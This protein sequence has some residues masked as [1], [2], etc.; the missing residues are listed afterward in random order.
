M[1]RD[2]ALPAQAPVGGAQPRAS[3]EGAAIG[4]AHAPPSAVEARRHIAS[5]EGALR[6]AQF[7]MRVTLFVLAVIALALAAPTLSRGTPWIDQPPVVLTIGLGGILGCLLVLTAIL[8]RYI[9]KPARRL[10]VA[11]DELG[12]LYQEARE[13]SLQDILTGL[14]NHRAFQEELDRRLSEVGR[15]DTELSLLLLDID[16]FKAVNDAHGHAVGDRVLSEMGATIRGLLRRPDLAFRIGGDEFALL[17]PHTNAEAARVVGRRLLAT[18]LQPRRDPLPSISFSAGISSAPAMARDRDE[19]Y[20]QAD[21]ALYRAK[22]Q[23]R[24][25]VEVF[26]RNRDRGASGVATNDLTAAVSRAASPA[27][28]RAV[29]QPIVEL[30]T[31]RVMG[32]EGLVR[33]TRQSGFDSPGP[34]FAAAELVGKTLELDRASLEV[35]SAGARAI[36]E[37]CY[38]AVN[39][40]PRTIEAPEF[41]VQMLLATLSEAGLPPERVVLELTEREAVEDVSRLRRNLHACQVAG[42][43]VAADDVGA[44]NAGLRLLSQIKFDIVKIDLSLVHNGVMLQPSLAVLKALTDLASSWGAAV[45]A[46]GV[47][48][49]DQLDLVKELGMTG[50]QG[51]LIGAPSARTD[52]E[53]VDLAEICARDLVRLPV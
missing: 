33:P 31:G 47:E 44:G 3:R 30:A 6:A 8:G 11:L 25:A 38:V 35:V 28:L 10:E 41:N 15:Y 21:T 27:M 51:Y 23:G 13:A 22:H 43:R 34:L 53:Y 48:T 49:A 26:D 18:A 16:E 46:E 7:R 5:T 39:M 45:I 20:Q 4:S 1:A 12:S 29:Y 36:S 32:Y 14:G 37:Q 52:L 17:M 2:T 19:L 40:S 50:G 9:L 24:T 42:V